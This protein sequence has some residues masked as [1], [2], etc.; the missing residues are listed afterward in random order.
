M[1]H[2]P[3]VTVCVVAGL[4]LI[5]TSSGQPTVKP[6]TPPTVAVLLAQARTQL[7]AGRDVSSIVSLDVTGTVTRGLDTRPKMDSYQFKLLLPDSFQWRTGPLLHSLERGVYG[8]RLVDDERYGGTLLS[9]MI[10][11]AK[12]QEA[13]AH[14]MQAN[15]MMVCLTFLAGLPPAMTT[16]VDDLGVRDFTKTRGRTISFHNLSERI[17][18]QLV[19]D[20]VT[21]QPLALVRHV[22]NSTTG[23]SA[24]RIAVFE[25]YRVVAGVR[26]PHRIEEWIGTS[27]ARVVVTRIAVNGL[28]PPDFVAATSRRR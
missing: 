21:A 9:K 3:F 4:S 24:D 25:D 18:M 6:G 26:F 15:F 16:T 13:A 23:E 11:D 28:A 12:S 19:L 20:A 8:Q 2:V 17:R 14:G 27:H 5:T 7:K 22:V 10:A 1:S